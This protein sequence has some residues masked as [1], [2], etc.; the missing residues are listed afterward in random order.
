MSDNKEESLISHLEALRETLL[1]CIISLCVG[2]P[3]TLYLAPYALNLLVKTIAGEGNITFNYFSPMEVFLIQL[4]TA[5]VLDIFLCFPY[6]AKKIWDFILPALYDNE[7]KFIKNIVLS[8]T[9]LF[10]L[11]ASFCI[12]VIMPMVVKFG[13]SFAGNNINPMFGISNIINLTL[14][15]AIAFGVM[16]QTPLVTVGVIKSGVISY[17]SISNMRPY[18]IVIILILAAIFTP[19]DVISQLM[20]GIP[21]YLLFEAGLL[22]AKLNLK[23]EKVNE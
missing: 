12:F 2:I 5:L 15:M 21:T 8:S 3:F 22:F 13:L 18:I 17:E 10:I 6:M 14:M 23:K 4:K 7:K 9:L 19:P 20:L 11:G 1:K 16:F